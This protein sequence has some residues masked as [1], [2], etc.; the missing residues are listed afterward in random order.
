MSTSPKVGKG[1]WISPEQ[2][3][4]SLGTLIEHFQAHR[5]NQSMRCIKRYANKV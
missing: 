2:Q 5:I 4:L 3:K 1:V